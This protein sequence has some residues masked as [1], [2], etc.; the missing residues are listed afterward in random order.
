PITFGLK[1]AGWLAG[2]LDAG[3]LLDEAAGRL[4]VQLGGAAG[5]LASLGADGPAVVQRFADRL[6]LAAPLLPWH[7]AR[8]RVAGLG[9]ALAVVTGTAAKVAGDI[10]LLA[11]SEVGEAA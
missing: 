5:T 7:T 9:A 11:Q 4:T 2:V 1:A 10:G 6:G 8:Q 3:E